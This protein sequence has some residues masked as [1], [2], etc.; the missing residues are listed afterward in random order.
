MAFK[1]IS[2]KNSGKKITSDGYNQLLVKVSVLM[3]RKQKSVG[4]L[5]NV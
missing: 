2:I 5:G 3:K 1:T 4:L